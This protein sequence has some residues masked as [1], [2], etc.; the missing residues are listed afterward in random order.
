[1]AT[2]GSGSKGNHSLVINVWAPGVNILLECTPTVAG[3]LEVMA[4]AEDGP[5]VR[6]Q[7]IPFATTLCDS[8]GCRLESHLASHTAVGQSYISPQLPHTGVYA[9]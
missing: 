1:M 8:Y 2:R 3:W 9:S 6:F 5:M 4:S 7:K